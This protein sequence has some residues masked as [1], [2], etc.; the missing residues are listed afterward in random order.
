MSCVAI[1][2]SGFNNHDLIYNICELSFHLINGKIVE[3]FFLVRIFMI[4]NRTP[5]FKKKILLIHCLQMISVMCFVTT[6]NCVLFF[7]CHGVCF[8][9]S[10]SLCFTLFYHI[11][12][13][14]KSAAP[15][16]APPL[17]P[18]VTQTL[19]QLLI[20]LS[21]ATHREMTQ[22]FHFQGLEMLPEPKISWY[23]S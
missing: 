21:A 6:R 8:H 12:L 3:F 13:S 22:T 20:S 5:P 2:S 9:L 17:S 11:S 16:A 4:S 1:V 10:S 14:S 7:S 18:A 19:H 15:P 23:S